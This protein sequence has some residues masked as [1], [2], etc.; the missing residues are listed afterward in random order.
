MFERVGCAMRELS[1]SETQWVKKRISQKDV[2]RTK[3][4]RGD[5][6]GRSSAGDEFSTTR[7]TRSCEDLSEI[8]IFFGVNASSY[9][10]GWKSHFASLLEL[11]VSRFCI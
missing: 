1:R 8:F 3:E 4:K 11:F 7:R 6:L 2:F 9:G 10:G 5:G